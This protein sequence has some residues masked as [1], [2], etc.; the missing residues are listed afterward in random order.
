MPSRRS[1]LLWLYERLTRVDAPRPADL[2]FVLAG[3]M[4]RKQYGLE[5]YRAGFADRLLLSVGRFE[6]SKMPRLSFDHAAELIAERDRTAPEQRHFFCD[7]DARRTVIHKPALRR[8]NT[9]GEALG[10]REHLSHEAVTRIIVV[11]TDIHL[12]RVA[13]AFDQVFRGSAVEF[14]YCPVLASQS[15]VWKEGWWTRPADRKYVISETVKLAAYRAILLMPE[16]MIRHC[17]GLRD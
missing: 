2:I 5:L 7:I 1:L 10:L 8:W 6:V 11:S 14:Q 15:S 9:Y 3:R 4:E 17:M 12:R 13:L 16:F